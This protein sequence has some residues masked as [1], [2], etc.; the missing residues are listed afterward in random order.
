[1]CVGYALTMTHFLLTVP[2][3]RLRAPSVRVPEGPA[4][5]HRRFL[6]AMLKVASPV[7]HPFDGHNRVAARWN[8]VAEQCLNGSEVRI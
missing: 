7:G 3:E 8:R 4:L 6:D 1:M 2:Q 5:V